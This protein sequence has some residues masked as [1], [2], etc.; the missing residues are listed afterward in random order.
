MENIYEL[1]NIVRNQQNTLSTLIPKKDSS[2]LKKLASLAFAKDRLSDEECMY[3]IFGKRDIASFTNLKVQLTE[4]L[5]LLLIMQFNKGKDKEESNIRRFDN[6][7]NILASNLIIA[8]GKK[9][10]GTKMLEKA[11]DI[12]VK[13]I[14]PEN[15]IIASRTLIEEF[16]SVRY[17]KYKYEK[18]LKLQEEYLKI[19]LLELKAQNYF[20]DLQ[21]TSINSLS[22]P[23]NET[24]ARAS[25][26]LQELEVHGNIKSPL[27]IYNRYRIEAFYNEYKRNYN[28][29]IY[30][31]N[32]ALKD[33]AI[34]GNKSS[35]AI[36]NIHIRI[37]VA[38]MQL[39]RFE[40]VIKICNEIRSKIME[41]SNSWFRIN[42]YLSKAY[43]YCG[44]YSR[45]ARLIISIYNNKN[46]KKYPYYKELNET[47]FG[48]LHLLLGAKYLNYS[49]Y[50]K[51]EITE[52]KLGKFLNSVPIY[53]KDKRG[54]N[55][56]ILLLH[57]A[58]LLQRKDYNTIIDRID[59]LKQ[60]AYRYLRRDDSF[61]SNCMIK[62]VIQMTKADF[63]PV[64]TERYT[65]DL[66]K[67]LKS[68]KL[69]GS[70]ENIEIE[71]IPF[72]VL[73]EIM[74]KSL[75]D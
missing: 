8:S 58:F 31:S 33:L 56:S 62:M 20:Y 29:L 72:E 54:I 57:I 34:P 68:V 63:H 59:A 51:I 16:G 53:S 9:E 22:M 74:L 7:K 36:L 25:K 39:A 5:F 18:Y 50:F 46:L 55:I 73:W 41:G 65:A 12:A 6:L 69:A 26:Y 1:I 66:F 60:Y 11:L 32:E 19:Y 71:V 30:I 3:K 75:K 28:R 40:E 23:S 49:I 47:M 21:R 15:V 4:K 2:P 27:F 13:R 70:G 45:S 14:I 48:Y 67:Q 43:I 35:N 61:R 44:E 38:Y 24:I 17:N 10:M 52:F 64:R 42:Y 37:I